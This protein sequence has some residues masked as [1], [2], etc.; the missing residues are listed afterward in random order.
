MYKKYEYGKNNI[1]DNMYFI[2]AFRTVFLYLF[3]VLCYRIMGKKEVGQLGIID[4]IVSFSIAELASI[5]IEETDKS[6]FTSIL[7]IT[8]LVLLE[9]VLGYI[10]MKSDKIRKALD[11]NPELIIN[12]GKL[13]FNTMKKL[14]YTIDDLLT[15]TR[16]K[17]IT[18][19][20]DIKYAVLETD[21]EL[22]IFKNNLYPLPLIVDGKVDNETLKNIG[23]NDMWLNNILK[24][25]NVI[26]KDI[27]YAF[28]KGND[29]Y[30]IKKN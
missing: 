13:N 4:L 6:I 7:P 10:S 3:I 30:I 23:K 22:S 12:K 17:E 21:G 28:Y 20:E 11:G 29:I 16:E 8:I 27:F 9:I 1:G 24:S 15:Q 19:L 18:N 26:L 2:I 14:R 5:S 25:R